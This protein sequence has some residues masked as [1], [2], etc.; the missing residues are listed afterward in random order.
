MRAAFINFRSFY[1]LVQKGKTDNG[2]HAREGSEEHITTHSHSSGFT[3][4]YSNATTAFSISEPISHMAS[5]P[6]ACLLPQYT[7]NWVNATMLVFL[8]AVG[9][10]WGG[11]GGRMQAPSPPSLS[12]NSVFTKWHS[13]AFVKDGF[14]NRGGTMIARRDWVCWLIPA[15][16]LPHADIHQPDA[17]SVINYL[18]TCLLAPDKC[19]ADLEVCESSASVKI[20]GTICYYK[21]REAS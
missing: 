20:C 6:Q 18:Q 21:W 11:E 19:V 7:A 9:G 3:A 13:S 14:I 5:S 4:R 1:S 15:C 2:L 8:K 10:G 17:T 12:L 16:L